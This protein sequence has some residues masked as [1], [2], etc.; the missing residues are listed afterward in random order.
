MSEPKTHRA[1]VATL[2][3]DEDE[4]VVTKIIMQLLDMLHSDHS[5]GQGEPNWLYWSNGNSPYELALDA[6]E[7]KFDIDFDIEWKE[8]HARKDGTIFFEG[9]RVKSIKIRRRQKHLCPRGE[10]D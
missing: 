2:Y 3:R 10:V 4:A 6:I 7:E 1:P 8:P 9:S 5:G